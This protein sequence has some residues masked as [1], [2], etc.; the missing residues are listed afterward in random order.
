MTDIRSRRTTALASTIAL[1][2]AVVLGAGRALTYTP[3][4]EAST[5]RHLALESSIPEA[6]ARVGAGLGEVRLFFTQPPQLSGTSIRVADGA[7][8]LM[9]A[10]EAVAVADDPSE[11][12][13]RLRGQLRPGSYTVYWRALAQDGHAANGSFEFSVATE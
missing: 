3:S 12:F 4:A 5:A 8:Q 10:T 6:D 11:I 7:E 2:L 9:E 1:S 13:V